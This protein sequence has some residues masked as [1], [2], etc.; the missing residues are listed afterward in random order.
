[1]SPLSGL[2]LLKEDEQVY[3]PFVENESS[4]Q[5]RE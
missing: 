2:S 1:M 3:K 5:L 4:N